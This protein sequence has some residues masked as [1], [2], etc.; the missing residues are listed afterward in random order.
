MREK[1][2]DRDREKKLTHEVLAIG[3]SK[4]LEDG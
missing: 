2:A 3:K 1:Q 4:N